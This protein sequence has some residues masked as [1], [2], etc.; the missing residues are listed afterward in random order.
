MYYYH[1]NCMER[2]TGRQSSQSV[3]GIRGTRCRY[4]EVCAVRQRVSHL[5]CRLAPSLRQSNGLEAGRLRTGSRGLVS[6]GKKDRWNQPKEAHARALCPP[7]IITRST[8]C[9]INQQVSE[10]RKTYPS[11]K[12]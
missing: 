5:P 7:P 8:S 10:F 1:C 4:Q 6:G 9:R 12:R 2:I 11:T 3:R